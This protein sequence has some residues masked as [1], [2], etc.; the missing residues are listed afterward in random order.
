MKLTS[1]GR[2]SPVWSK[3]G[4]PVWTNVGVAHGGEKKNLF[5]GEMGCG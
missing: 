4:K 2:R 3:Q 1:V 5:I